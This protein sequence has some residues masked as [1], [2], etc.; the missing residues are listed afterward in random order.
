MAVKCASRGCSSMAEQK[1]PKLTTRVR[2]PSPAP[3]PWPDCRVAPNVAPPGRS[4]GEDDATEAAG[5]IVELVACAGRARGV[6][7][8][9]NRLSLS[10]AALLASEGACMVVISRD[11]VQPLLGA[12]D[13]YD[14]LIARVGDA[15][16]VLIGEASHGTD[17]FYRE[18][19]AITR[20][21]ITEKGFGAVAVEADWPDAYRVNRYV[22]GE[23]RDRS[24]DEALSG[25]RRFPAW[26]WRNEVV[27]DFVTWL[28]AHNE[29][30]PAAPAGFYGLDLYSLFTS[31]DEVLRYLE[32]VDPPAAKRAR[33]RYSCFDHFAE[34]TQA[35]GYAATFGLEKPCVDEAV[36]QLVELRRRADE[37]MRADGLVA[38]EEFFQAEQNARLVKNAEE[39]YRSMFA[40]R[41]SSWNLRDTHMAETLETLARH[42]DARRPGAKVV[43]WAHNSHLGDAR[44][45]Q[46][47]R[48]GEINLGQ[49]VRERHAGEAALIG[50]STYAGTVTA[51]TEWGD[52]NETKRLRPGLEG[53]YEMLFHSLGMPRF[54]LDLS[55]PR[56]P[57][58]RAE[59]LQRAIGVIYRPETERESHYFIARLADQFDF[60]I[61]IDETRALAPLEPSSEMTAE[62]PETYPSG[63]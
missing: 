60:M 50:F 21:L 19:A 30:D 32:E 18:R 1:L 4:I 25:F 63:I 12:P 16:F 40:G 34:D 58:R 56:A 62:P 54:L 43:V 23:S 6:K 27:L 26:M 20:R 36:A 57:G 3:R 28:R 15:R 42:L 7:E 59:L 31:M 53:S 9:D 29:S 55:D 51:A 44:A 11:G 39:Y 17:E 47:G 5:E 37:Y 13:D 46:M 24:A 14:R 35:Y 38:S 48:E 2:F 49:L 22:R 33:Y 52:P 8:V 61:H 45:T 41:V 10:G